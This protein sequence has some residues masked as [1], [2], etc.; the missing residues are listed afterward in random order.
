MLVMTLVKMIACVMMMTMLVMMVTLMR[1][2]R[3]GIADA[4]DHKK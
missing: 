4:V 1:R 3:I 2:V